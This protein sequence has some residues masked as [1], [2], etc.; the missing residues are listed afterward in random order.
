MPARDQDSEIRKSRGAAENAEDAENRRVVL[1]DPCFLRVPCVISAVRRLRNQDGIRRGTIEAHPH[2]SGFKLAFP[3][4]PFPD[5][6][7]PKERMSDTNLAALRERLAAYRRPAWCPDTVEG[8][9]AP[10]ASKFGGAPALRPG[11][12]WPICGNCG[13]PMQ[14]FLQLNPRDLPSAGAERLDGGVLQLFYC[15]SSEPS[16][17]V[18]CEA[19]SPRAVSTLVRLV[20]AAEAA[21]AMPVEV[22]A[23]MFPPKRIVG[24]AEVDDYPLSEELDEM[25]VPL[26]DADADL[27]YGSGVP[28][29]GDKL[30][31][32]PAWVQSVEYPECPECGGP[33]ELLFQLDSE[34]HLPFMF[35]DVG[36]GHVTQCRHHPGQLAFGWACT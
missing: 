25:G 5:L 13:G 36:T 29:T 16:C 33:M 12:A 28:R 20:P 21:A 23:G 31:G 15:T 14:L 34:D 22:P 24:W 11:E 26:T 1:R 3:W 2:L 35:G 19:W 30:L 9:G 10:D 6:D 7:L 8:D 32:W 27:L 4:A 18:D 17:D